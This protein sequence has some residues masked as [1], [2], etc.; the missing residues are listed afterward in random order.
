MV[1][2]YADNYLLGIVRSLEQVLMSLL[3]YL[4]VGV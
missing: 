3:Y 2:G 4:F 1:G